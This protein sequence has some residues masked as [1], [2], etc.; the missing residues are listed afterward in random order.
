MVFAFANYGLFWFMHFV[1]VFALANY[2]FV[3]VYRFVPVFRL[4]DTHDRSKHF[5]PPM[6]RCKTGTAAV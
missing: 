4:L 6:R 3:K 1:M 5:L 2:H